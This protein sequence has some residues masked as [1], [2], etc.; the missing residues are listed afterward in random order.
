VNEADPQPAPVIAR[1]RAG[2]SEIPD[3]GRQHGLRARLHRAAAEHETLPKFFKEAVRLWA[4]T[5]L[6]P[7]RDGIAARRTMNEMTLEAY[8]IRI[9][10]GAIEPSLVESVS[11]ALVYQTR[12]SEARNTD[13]R[14]RA[15][16]LQLWFHR[17]VELHF[18]PHSVDDLMLPDVEGGL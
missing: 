2:V 10:R 11:Y 4:H 5:I 1:L 6:D 18:L 13:H 14:L 16:D 12:R 15:H 9:L 3:S 17:V 7:K 8:T